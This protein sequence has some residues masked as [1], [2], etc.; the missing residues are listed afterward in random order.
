MEQLSFDPMKYAAPVIRSGLRHIKFKRTTYLGKDT[1]KLVPGFLGLSSPAN[2]TVDYVFDYPDENGLL[3][4]PY[5][6]LFVPVGGCDQVFQLTQGKNTI[7]LRSKDDIEGDGF[8]MDG[9]LEFI[10]T[11]YNFKDDTFVIGNS[12]P[13]MR[14]G[15]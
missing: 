12:P 7:T 13:K 11:V 8:K 9:T 1:F 14:L 10:Y 5:P 3:M 6:G 4:V 2:S 15:P